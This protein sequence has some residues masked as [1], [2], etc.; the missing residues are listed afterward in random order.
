MPVISAVSR[1]VGLQAAAITVRGLDV[2]PGSFAG[3]G[4]ALLKEIATTLFMAVVCGVVLGL[5]GGFW[6][7]HLVFGLVIGLA[8]QRPIAELVRYSSQRQAA[9]AMPTL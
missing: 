4:K 5:I 6:S 7:K 8:S 2:G 9:V 1:N 3:R